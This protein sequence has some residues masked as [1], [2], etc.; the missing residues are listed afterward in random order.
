ME[1]PAL[2]SP[3]QGFAALQ[4]DEHA[5]NLS[6]ECVPY[7]GLCILLAVVLVQLVSK[8]LIIE[9]NSSFVAEVL[10]DPFLDSIVYLCL[11]LES[12]SMYILYSVVISDSIRSCISSAYHFSAVGRSF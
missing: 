12:R 1:T 3:D 11:L 8:G 10:A 6:R 5:S 2:S 9:C 7:K 4:Q